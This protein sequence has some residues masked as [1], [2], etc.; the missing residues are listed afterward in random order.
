MTVLILNQAFHPDVAATAQQA[1]DLAVRLVERGHEVTV[2]CSRRAYDNPAER[3]PRCETWH[4]VKIKR[5]SSLMLG[6]HSRWRRAVSFAS[7]LLNCFVRLTLLPRADLVIGMTSPPLISSLAAFFSR[8]KGGHFIFWVMDLNPD[9]ALAAGWLRPGSAT[10]AV[11]Q[12]LLQYGLDRATTVVTLDQHMAKRIQ[13]KGIARSHIAVVPPWAREH[14]V[15]YDPIGRERFRGTHGLTGK[16]V[17]MYSGNHSPC[18]PLK[19]LLEAAERLRE[20]DDIIFCF[21][22]GGSEVA[23]VR[24]EVAARQL[25]HVRLLPYQ[26]SEI[27]AAS[28]S[29]ADLHVVVMGDAFVGIVHPCKVYNIR[30]LGL[31]YLYIGPAESHI[32]ELEPTFAARHGDSETVARHVAV[33]ARDLRDRVPQVASL[34]HHSH[35]HMVTRM[36]TMLEAVAAGAANADDVD[37]TS[38]GNTSHSSSV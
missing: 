10:T 27:L 22:G 7:Y 28:L 37:D 17:V 4:G 24:R 33:A 3:Y 38:S 32:S 25:R 20:R 26:P 8:F 1:S 18:H 15:Q 35:Q 23:T 21:I 29:A 36:A 31:P 13:S 16:F 14:V 5:I 9:E 19:T 30:I 34:Q 6:K 12:K 2:L 11:L